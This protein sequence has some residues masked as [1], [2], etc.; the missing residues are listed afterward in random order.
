FPEAWDQRNGDTNRPKLGFLPLGTGNS[1]LRDFTAEAVEDATRALLTDHARPCDVIRLTH[2][3][4]AIHYIN[5]LSLGIVADVCHLANRKFKRLGEA[6]Y[7]LAV[8]LC[9][10]RFHQYDFRLRFDNQKEVEQMRTALLIFNNSKYTGGKMMLAPNA[11]TS[12]GLI[13]IVRWT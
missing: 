1:F 3:T 4:G 8:V 5:I 13:D 7:M 11:D 12:D 6:G 10:A 9:L 2:K